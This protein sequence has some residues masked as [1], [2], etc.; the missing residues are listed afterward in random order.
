MAASVMDELYALR[1]YNREAVDAL[2]EEMI[3]EVRAYR[4]RELREQA[5]MTQQ[6]IAAE[7]NVSQNSVS[8]LE[9]GDL[10]KTQIST[11]KRYIEALGGNLSIEANFGDTSYRLA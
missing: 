5:Q 4:L 2:A 11:L 6:N 7:L 1:P 3:A 8:K 10:D 9:R